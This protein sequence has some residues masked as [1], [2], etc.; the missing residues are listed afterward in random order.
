MGFN[1]AKKLEDVYL[2]NAGISTTDPEADKGKIPELAKGLAT[3]IDNYI[4]SMTF[5]IT[6]LDA[7]VQL[8]EIKITKK[9]FVTIPEL[10]LNPVGLSVGGVPVVGVART[11]KS[12]QGKTS[13]VTLRKNDFTVKGRAYL[14]KAARQEVKNADAKYDRSAERNIVH[15]TVSLDPNSRNV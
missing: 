7:V 5:N 10:M 1:L 2:T 11:A 12:P 9:M 15:A 4:K 6:N 13:P 14:G 3:V 8:D